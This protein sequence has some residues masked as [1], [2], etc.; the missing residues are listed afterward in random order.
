MSEALS[1]AQMRGIERAAIDAGHVTGLELMERAGRGVVEAM[2]AWRPELATAP[3]RAAVLCGPG[4]NG[5]DGFVVARLLR[6]RGWEVEVLLYGRDP[7]EI[8]KLP[9]DAAANARRW[10]PIGG[11]QPLASQTLPAGYD[12]C[13][14]AI[15]GTGL[16]RDLDADLAEIVETLDAARLAGLRQGG[17]RRH[18]DGALLRQRAAAAGG[19]ARRADRDLPPGEDRPLSRQRARLLRTAG[20][21]GHR[22]R[23]APCRRRGPRERADPWR[24]QL[25]KT[26]AAHK[27]GYGHALVLSGG[28]G[29]GG[30]AR[31]AAARRR[32]ASARGW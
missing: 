6:E 22:P 15:F 25:G 17:L 1:A 11:I 9:P 4:N 19:A 28:V 30:A 2:L 32:C 18:A 26:G 7:S 16:A 3:H 13:V 14:D 27:Y 31:L 24:Q 20:R 12:I 10:A 21:G 23:P 29:K 8:D 5:G